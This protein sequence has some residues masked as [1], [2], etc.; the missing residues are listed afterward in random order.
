MMY[1]HGEKIDLVFAYIVANHPYL[2][3]IG[4]F[5]LLLLSLFLSCLTSIRVF[6]F[7]L[8]LEDRERNIT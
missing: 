6:L 8:R 3:M 4:S 7:F 5:F 2:K 1:I